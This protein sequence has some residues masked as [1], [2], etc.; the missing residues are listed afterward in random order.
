[1]DWLDEHMRKHLAE[2]PG[3]SNV[4][5]LR[6]QPSLIEEVG[7]RTVELVERAIQHIQNV[8]EEAAATHA[9]AETLARNALERLKLGEERV[10][11][12]ES[13]RQAAE[14]RIEEATAKLRDMEIQLERTAANAAAAEERARDAERRA[15]DAENA[16]K[17][18]ETLVHTLMLEKRLSTG[19]VTA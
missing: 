18:I 14:A 3:E 12:A 11:A 9:R 4:L 16:L 13:A 1:M 7:A 8:E 6:P 10:R 19:G 15:T 2:T 5:T 17:R